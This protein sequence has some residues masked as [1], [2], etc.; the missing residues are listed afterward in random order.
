M[1]WAVISG[2]KE[3]TEK[4]KSVVDNMTSEIS[5]LQEQANERNL[6]VSQG[7]IELS[8]VHDAFAIRFGEITELELERALEA[9]SNILE[10]ENM[11]KELE[12]E[13][14]ATRWSEGELKRISG[15]APEPLEKVDLENVILM[16]RSLAEQLQTLRTENEKRERN[17]RMVE[18][19]ITTS[20]TEIQELQAK[21]EERKAMKQIVAERQ[22]KLN[23][24][25]KENA[26]LTEGYK[27]QTRL[28]KEVQEKLSAA[29]HEIQQIE[30]FVGENEKGIRETV[31]MQ[32]E[33]QTHLASLERY[34]EPMR[35]MKRDYDVFVNNSRK[36]R[37][38]MTN[39]LQEIDELIEELE[40]RTEGE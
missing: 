11:E 29:N 4:L 2:L 18:K 7:E 23:A 13:K 1:S 21:I 8:L 37:E 27:E 15:L 32:K 5:K 17:M 10:I 14:E 30:A 40:R 39:H 35:E 20:L 33:I 28:M 31:K 25:I 22:K 12:R 3:K 26:K 24:L 34:N 38:E 36:L 19:K 16:R 9:I 6:R